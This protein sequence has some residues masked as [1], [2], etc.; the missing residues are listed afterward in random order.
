[1]NKEEYKEFRG[2]AGKL[3]WPSEMPRPDLQFDCLEL[4]CKN[5]DAKVDDIR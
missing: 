4:S 3:T 2:D 5:P 1:M